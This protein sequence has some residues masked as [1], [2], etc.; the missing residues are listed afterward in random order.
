LTIHAAISFSSSKWPKEGKSSNIN[1]VASHVRYEHA[2]AQ[3]EIKVA[4]LGLNKVR[5]SSSTTTARNAAKARREAGL[6]VVQC[7]SWPT[8]PA[9]PPPPACGIAG[10]ARGAGI[11]ACAFVGEPWLTFGCA[12]CGI[13]MLHAR[14]G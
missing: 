6:F 8:P 2:F 4:D 5:Y 11:C 3:G 14:S 13:H 12:T 7:R 10:A 9:C 1:R